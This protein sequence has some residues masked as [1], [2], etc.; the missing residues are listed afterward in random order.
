[1]RKN[2]GKTNNST[3]SFIGKLTQENLHKKLCPIYLALVAVLPSLSY[4]NLVPDTSS[5]APT[6]SES[7]NGT[8]TVNIINPN[9]N[10]ISHNKFDDFNVGPD[11]LIFNNSMQDGVS[12]IGGYI[13]KNGQLQQE[14]SAI[15]SEV[16]GAKGSYLNGTMEVFGKK[17]DLIIANENGI[18]VNG[19][20]TINAN[21]L[22]LSTGRVEYGENGN[23]QL[24]VNKGMIAVEG[25]GLSTE[26]LTHFDM[27]S[28]TVKLDGEVSGSA[29]IKV[30]A[31]LNTYDT[32]TRQHQIR[33]LSAA[34]TPK[35]AIDGSSLGSMYGGR[36]QLIST[37]SGVGV[38]HKGSLVGNQTVEISADGDLALTAISSKSG[39]VNL[40]GNNIDISVNENTGFGGVISNG[41]LIIRA[42]SQ[43]K[44]SADAVSKNG[45]IRITADSLLQNAARIFAMSGDSDKI[46]VTSIFI[47]V[48]GE[49][50]ITGT[51]FALDASGKKIENAIISLVD[52]NYIVSINGETIDSAT[53]SS[54]AAIS[55]QSGNVIV[56]ANSF[57]NQGAGV[58][59]Q[60]GTLSFTINELFDNDGVVNA[61]GPL[62]I[63][64]NDLH[65]KGVLYTEQDA[66]LILGSLINKGLLQAD[67]KNTIKSNSINNS[68]RIVSAASM[69]DIS[70]VN[71][72]AINSGVLSG[73]NV[74]IRQV[75]DGGLLEN[76]GVIN[77]EESIDITTE[78]VFN[79]GDITAAKD[80]SLNISKEV[81]NQNGG[82]ILSGA[83]LKINSSGVHAVN[84]NNNN[85]LIQGG[86][87]EI[88]NANTITNSNNAKLISEGSLKLDDI[89]ELNNKGSSSLIQ[90][91]EIIL[92]NIDSIKNTDEAKILA[93]DQLSISHS[94]ELINQNSS[95]L[96]SGDIHLSNIETIKNVDGF[97]NADGTVSINNST[98][99][100]NTGTGTTQYSGSGIIANN[101]DIHSVA[102]VENSGG[103]YIS[104]LGEW[105]KLELINS[106]INDK[107]GVITSDNG[108]MISNIDN[109]NNKGVIYS[110][111][112]MSLANIG[113]LSNIGDGTGNIGVINAGRNLYVS[114]VS[115]FINS[116]AAIINSDGD[117]TFKNINKLDNI[118]AIIQASGILSVEANTIVNSSDKGSSAGDAIIIGVGGL[119]VES[120]SISNLNGAT[121]FSDAD[122][123][124]RSKNVNNSGSNISGNN[125]D[126]QSDNLNN[127]VGYIYSAK[128][129]LIKLAESLN[130]LSGDIFSDN[131]LS[132]ILSK[133]YRY[134]DDS[135]DINARGEFSIKTTGSII[136]DRILE[137]AASIL[138]NADE[139]IKISSNQS[140]LSLK[141]VILKAI[142]I[143]NSSGALI[144]SSQDI[145]IDAE[146]GKFLNEENANVLSMG[147]IDIVAENI[148]NDGGNIRSQGDMALDAKIIDN[149]SKYDN[150]GWVTGPAQNA[151]GSHEWKQGF[152][153]LVYY[154]AKLSGSIPTWIGDF[155]LTKMAEISSGG[156]LNINQ[157]NIYSTKTLNNTG[158]IIQSSKDMIISGTVNNA[159]EYNEMSFFYYLTE[160]LSTPIELEVYR[161]V[162]GS[163]SGYAQFNT[164][165]QLLD[166]YFGDG[167][168]ESVSGQGSYIYDS[169]SN[170]FNSLKEMAKQSEQ[171]NSVM[172]RLFGDAWLSESQEK[173]SQDWAR[174]TGSNNASLKDLK[175]Y[176][177]SDNNGGIIA[178]GNLTH[179]GGAFNNGLF[180]AK[181]EGEKITVAI[182]DKEVV[183]TQNPYEINI[184]LKTIAELTKGL[185]TTK[186]YTE[187]AKIQGLFV[188][189]Q[190][191]KDVDFTAKVGDGAS[192]PIYPFYET[193]TEMI[194]QSLFFGSQYFFDQIGYIP[195]TP[196]LVVGDN[197]FISE[198]IRRQLNESVGTFFSVR[199][200]VDGTELVEKLMSNAA[201]VNGVEDFTVGKALTDEQIAGLDKDI[202][203]FVTE[204]IDGHDVLTP[205]IYFATTT[206]EQLE[207]G[208]YDGS[209]IVHAGGNM[210]VDASS[211][212]NV[213]GQISAGG[214]I[215]IQ[216]EGNI[217]N[218]SVGMNGGIT[219]GGDLSLVSS[220]GSITNSGAALS[221]GNDLTL[222]ADNGSIELT[223]SQGANVSGNQELHYYNDGV[224]AGGSI[225]MSAKDIT[226]N[227][228]DIAA[229]K[230]ISLTSTEGDVTFN[231]MYEVEGNY[232]YSHK[233]TGILSHESTET[234]S[235]S[236]TSVDSSVNAGGKF[237]VNSANDIVLKGGEYNAQSGELKA[238]GDVDIQTSQDYSYSETTVERT[239][240]KFGAGAS[241][242]GQSAGY[243][244]SG[245]DGESSSTST[246]EHNN[247][248]SDITNAGSKPG[249]APTSSSGNF[250]AG[251]ETVTT[252]DTQQTTTNN[253]ASLN[254]T[255]SMTLEAGNTV[256][257]GGGNFNTEGALTIVADEVKSTKYEDEVITTSE[258]TVSFYGVKGEAHSS[259][260]DA[261]DKVGNL[262]EKGNDG[263]EIDAGLTAA[264]VAGSASNLMFNDLLGGSVS[265]GF[266]T[267]TTSSSS[268]TKSENITNINAGNVSIT[269]NGDT[270]LKGV[271]L[272]A[273]SVEI[274]TGGDLNI[275]AAE[276][277]TESWSQK[278]THS[279]GV[280]AGASAAPTG[281]GAGVS[282]DYHGS[283]ST[284][285][286][287][288]HTYT[289]SNLNSSDISINTGGDMTLAGGNIQSETANLNITG[290][291]NVQS[292]QDT[293][294][295][296]TN[297]NEWG[298]SVGV[299][300]STN[301]GLIPTLAGNYG[302]GGEH[303]DSKTTG[304]QTGI[305]T[306]GELNISTGGDL[307]LTGAHIVSDS[308][309]GTVD[310][311]GNINAVEL[312]DTIDQDGAYGGGG[313]GI[314]KTGLPTVNG[315]YNTV[316]KV[317][318]QEDQKATID[319]G[320]IKGNVQGELN[321][322]GET[323]SQVNVDK[324]TASN[325]ISFTAGGLSSSNKPAKNG[326]T[327]KPPKT[328][329]VKTDKPTPPKPTPVETDK[330]T[331]PKP[332]PVETDKPTPPKPTPV[333]TDKPTPPKPTP[334]ETD[335]P[336]PPKPTPVETDKPTPPKPTP[337]ETDKPTPPKPTPVETDK[338]TPPKPTPVET[339]KPTP[340]KPAP[341]ETDKP[342]PPKNRPSKPVKGEEK[343]NHMSPS[344]PGSKLG[345]DFKGHLPKD[346]KNSSRWIKKTA[347]GDEPVSYPKPSEIRQSTPPSKAP[348]SSG[349]P[350]AESNPNHMSPSYPGSKQDGSF[351]GS[352]PKDDGTS[353]GWIKHPT[354]SVPTDSSKR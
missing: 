202:V 136:I 245:L 55:S 338:P 329:P 285:T 34:D 234:V 306:T 98:N 125:V 154:N 347:T 206:L 85:S 167:S 72:S 16:T 236:A 345:G 296:Q 101:I 188:S 145:I 198:V 280:S 29:D 308:K 330:P 214:N 49:Y 71:G 242:F 14:A 320:N 64:A 61:S 6:I 331:P 52:G 307:N 305:N 135:G 168:P 84:I 25:Q 254:F 63:V 151:E 197:Y 324:V 223:A 146:K 246:G 27:I 183:V 262:V 334:V 335:K 103:S 201:T 47:D 166:F 46:D 17:A 251:L 313:G 129:L 207:S 353:S 352:L 185:S 97:I 298:G 264:E 152:I 80:L 180:G 187:L 312:S 15:I 79:S 147:K 238:A 18:S 140:I 339:D 137:S 159:P 23:I 35:V 191:W 163:D 281:A 96:A 92:T 199:D 275:L 252:V 68:G 123:S 115:S 54:D 283:T 13:I 157:K 170:S 309:T 218:S 109:L 322:D 212:N 107:S 222:Q 53:I 286:G 229:E 241:G 301:G 77:S 193:R 256:D 76:T 263:Q 293:V 38:R 319:V 351:V 318:Y 153:S 100:F 279:A 209:A 243:D 43:A 227:A 200:G 343:P 176:G 165:Y 28:R 221:A 78:S 162:I 341:V 211:F 233:S 184:G 4:A 284:S 60:K 213:N 215:N 128:N 94:S 120:D 310:V 59:S 93:A 149:I 323:L 45:N 26:G 169:K 87:I 161:K 67:K 316:E 99:L 172:K 82:S 105:L 235:S 265:V 3:S 1:M 69:L 292:V 51:L 24:N 130:N 220:G 7:A 247:L 350:P 328:A 164:L 122:I 253:N 5:N 31:G 291:L 40:S 297:S 189:N 219:S 290:D 30:V 174:V 110:G 244:I 257:I 217:N 303:Y 56:K 190:K 195:E 143:T 204:N 131:N 178:G 230:D 342:T 57:L 42:L 302:Q 155:K 88:S 75:S 10:G 269:S 258:E 126:I 33:N 114:Y 282:V 224:T 36:I 91:N 22:T 299:A 354:I 267:T 225:D 260:A 142:N 278:D 116:I 111:A 196:V 86:A 192:N 118:N 113:S 315:Y 346:D 186:T 2:K 108:L 216:S 348:V 194:D 58:N 277:S 160:T 12:S 112:D 270:T 182:G 311:A 148:K 70:I 119:T 39:D 19:V 134:N 294:N 173:L 74:A 228:V 124:I 203:W 48:K 8:P 158:G 90:A 273:D 89:K 325:S 121:L 289:N 144:F 237:T 132:L 240:L 37:E 304:T 239:D 181:L 349:K 336:T 274:T 73:K 287:S 138:L 261:A 11:G 66:N 231:N 65:N 259:V 50:K 133:D 272:S 276:S 326:N 250:Q 139:N 62:S 175:D 44:L 340:P 226:V 102:N 106:I 150:P 314:S 333:E 332:T 232:E 179:N 300:V 295:N 327:S 81:N 104:A 95:I 141:D 266:D 41:D 268:T 248:G 83:N 337:V 177:L 317:E 32:Q 208:R 9:G 255:D 20:S 205:K 117:A 321:T 288:S 21:N 344:Y 156:N 127:S 271:E 210:D 171:L 249:R